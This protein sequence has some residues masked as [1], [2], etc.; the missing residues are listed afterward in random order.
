MANDLKQTAKAVAKSGAEGVGSVA[1]EA[2]A[3]GAVTAAGVVITRVAAGSAA[4]G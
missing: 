4:T 3:A 1:A 2:L